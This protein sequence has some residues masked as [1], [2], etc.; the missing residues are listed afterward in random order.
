MTA[1]ESG[2]HS[3][4][5]DVSDSEPVAPSKTSHPGGQLFLQALIA[6]CLAIEAVLWLSDQGFINPQRLRALAYDYGVFWA[7]LWQDWPANY[8]AQPWM[9]F[10]TYGLLHG[11]VLHVAANMVTLWSLGGAVLQRVGTRGVILLYVVA[12]LGGGIGFVLLA[13]RAFFFLPMVGASG[14]LFGLAGG[15][16]AW[17]YVDRYTFSEA[18]WPVAR[19]VLILGALNIVMWWALNGQLA[20]ETHLGGFVAGWIMA[21]LIDPRPQ[22]L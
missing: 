13:D 2:S 21:L 1:S 5:Q 19:M 8:A 3:D 12:Q 4:T 20:W 14:A 18:I 22:R 16:L 7:G 10:L 17:A 6:I 15:L 11:G 9:M